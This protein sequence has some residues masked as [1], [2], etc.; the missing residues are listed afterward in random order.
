MGGRL[1]RL[2]TEEEAM[3]MKPTAVR[4][5]TSSFAHVGGRDVRLAT[6]L[7]CPH[8][9]RELQASDVSTDEDKATWLTC[10]GCHRDLL[11]IEAP[12]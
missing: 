6:G 10:Q 12:Q 2:T 7:D 8:C 4:P 1:F 11:L 9:G 5:P 3:L